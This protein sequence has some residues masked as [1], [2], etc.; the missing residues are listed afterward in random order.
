MKKICFSLLS[1]VSLLGTLSAQKN[2]EPLIQTKIQY[3]TV[4]MN[5][6]FK[7]EFIF[8][9]AQNVDFTNPVFE[10]F[11]IVQG[12]SQSSQFTMVNGVSSSS[13]KYTYLVR[14]KDL[15]NFVIGSQKVYINNNVYYTP[16]SA[17]VVVDEIK[18]SQNYTN[19]FDLPSLGFDDDIFNRMQK[20]QEEMLRQNKDF[21]EN[22]DKYFNNPD[23][24]SFPRQFGPNF[25]DIFK[26]FDNLFQ[27]KLPPQSKPTKPAD[28]TYKL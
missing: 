19:P 10:W 6:L 27:F 16:E 17:V 12:P 13:V 14:A 28:K 5:E 2:G 20:Q 24:F 26:N 15:G 22:S 11:D 9:N 4:G 21:F 7:L 1:I 23:F 18:R 25:E 8:E 3:D